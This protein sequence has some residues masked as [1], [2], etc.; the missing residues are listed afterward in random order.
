MFQGPTLGERTF[1]KI[2]KQA[3]ALANSTSVQTL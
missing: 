1:P 3:L 2:V